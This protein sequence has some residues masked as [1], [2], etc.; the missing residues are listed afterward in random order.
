MSEDNGIDVGAMTEFVQD[1]CYDRNCLPTHPYKLE[2]AVIC[3]LCPDCHRQSA[4][5]DQNQPGKRLSA[6]LF[7]EYEIGKSDG[8]DN[9]ELIDRY[10]NADDAVLYGVI[11]TEP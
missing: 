8:N 5:N 4:D 6:Q 1:F 7:F 2:F 3:F 10:D 9:A 11:V